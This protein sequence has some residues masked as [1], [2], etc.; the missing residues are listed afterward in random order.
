MS[1]SCAPQKAGWAAVCPAGPKVRP[2]PAAGLPGQSR[3]VMW[4][5]GAGPGRRLDHRAGAAGAPGHPAGSQTPVR[6][7]CHP[8]PAELPG[9]VRAPS[10][11]T[12]PRPFLR[13]ET[14][15]PGG[16]E[17]RQSMDLLPPQ[18]AGAGPRGP[19]PR[20]RGQPGSR[21]GV[22]AGCHRGPALGSSNALRPD[23]SPC[24]AITVGFI[25]ACRRCQRRAQPA[26]VTQSGATPGPRAR[27]DA[28]QP[29]D[30]PPVPPFEARGHCGGWNLDTP[31]AW[32]SPL[33]QS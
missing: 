6:C 25:A 10:P 9:P 23:R 20:T 29:D 28:S 16:E 11:C 19:A 5:P 1:G 2:L 31:G 4:S 24:R 13:A 33:L 27:D 17:G 21:P 12:S 32:G 14:G 22:L 15:N 8:T 26:Q 7:L 3:P 18:T 30:P